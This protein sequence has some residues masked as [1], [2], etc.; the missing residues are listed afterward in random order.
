M[1]VQK[2]TDEIREEIKRQAKD[3]TV[4]LATNHPVKPDVLR[5][6]GQLDLYEIAKALVSDMMAQARKEGVEVRE[7]R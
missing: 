6:V 4:L 7:V 1:D 3:G 2:L 5:I